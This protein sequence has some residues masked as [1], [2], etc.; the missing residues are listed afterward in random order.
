MNQ[1]EVEHMMSQAQKV[2]ALEAALGR[3]QRS[4]DKAIAAIKEQRQQIEQLE[5]IVHDFSQEQGQY[6]TDHIKHLERIEQ[7]E[8]E[9]VRLRAALRVAVDDARALRDALELLACLGNGV[10]YGNSTGNVIAQKALA[11]LEKTDE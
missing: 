1:V 9:N 8:A 3:K 2:P 5:S 10:K 6:L 4:F 7:L 11:A